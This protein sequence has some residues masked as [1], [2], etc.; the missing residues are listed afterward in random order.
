VLLHGLLQVVEELLHNNSM[1]RRQ[2]L[3]I[4]QHGSTQCISGSED[5]KKFIPEHPQ[6]TFSYDNIVGTEICKEN[7]GEISRIQY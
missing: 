2:A 1:E 4:G 3:K 5:C 6:H 7:T